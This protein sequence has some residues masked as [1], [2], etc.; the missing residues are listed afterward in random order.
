MEE[1]LRKAREEKEEIRVRGDALQHL[2]ED[3][4]RKILGGALKT[5]QAGIFRQPYPEEK[6]PAEVFLPQAT[7]HSLMWF[8]GI[9]SIAV[10]IKM[11]MGEGNK[12]A[13]LFASSVSGEGTTTVSSNVSRALA[14]ICPGNVLLLDGNSLHPEVHKIFGTEAGPG[15]TDILAGKI[16]WEVA[17]RETPLK[18]FYILPFGQSIQEPLALIG[19]GRMEELLNVL[20]SDF[21]YILLDTPPILVSAEAEMIVPW[22]EASVLVIKAHVT[23]RE[24]ARRAAERIIQHKDF[25]GAIFNQ[26]KFF[27]PQF[28]YKRLK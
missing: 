23:R 20:K 12:G 7:P 17:I 18:N 14:T 26:Q 28:L 1:A 4:V 8:K 13:I 27:I 24:V 5:E 3:A 2:V 25:L 6:I 16:N 22:V 11:K 15:L 10:N 9:N 19:S 21:D